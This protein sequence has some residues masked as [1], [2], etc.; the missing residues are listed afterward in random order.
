MMINGLSARYTASNSFLHDYL[1][2]YLITW[3]R[4]SSFI[5]P[6]YVIVRRI[7]EEEAML[8]H[9]FGNQWTEYRRRTWRLIP[10]VW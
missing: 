7:G 4:W 8:E 3:I 1:P 10:L 5:A 2:W 9:E 6:T